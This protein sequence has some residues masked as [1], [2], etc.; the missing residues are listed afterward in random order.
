MA[1]PEAAIIA[2]RNFL[3]NTVVEHLFVYCWLTR[4]S[5]LIRTRWMIRKDEAQGF[6]FMIVNQ[7]VIAPNGSTAGSREFSGLFVESGDEFYCDIS[8]R[9]GKPPVY[10]TSR[11]LL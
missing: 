5:Y 1:S 11:F 8:M 6:V 10:V 9:R 2:N 7:F 3:S 4:L